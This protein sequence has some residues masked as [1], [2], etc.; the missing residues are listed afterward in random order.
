MGRGVGQDKEFHFA[1]LFLGRW[2]C[3][4]ADV[5]KRDSMLLVLKMRAR[6]ASIFRRP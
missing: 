2:G 1:Q 3:D 5:E 6:C 4:A